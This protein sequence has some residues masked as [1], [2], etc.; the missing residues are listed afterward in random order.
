MT[1]A[2][3]MK[4]FTLKNEENENEKNTIQ[5]DDLTTV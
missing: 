2:F 1:D 4:H 5:C 3:E